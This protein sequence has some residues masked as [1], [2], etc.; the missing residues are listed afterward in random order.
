M[1]YIDQTQA[2]S[3]RTKAL[4]GVAAI[5]ALIGYGLIN[6]LTIDDF[7]P[8]AAPPPLTI[9]DY[10]DP[11]PPDPAPT[12]EPTTEPRPAADQ[13][14]VAPNPT[15]DFTRPQLPRIAEFDPTAE[16]GPLIEIPAPRPDPGRATPTPQPSFA[17]KGPAPSNSTLNWVRT[18][19][20]PG[21]ALR[22]EQEGTVSYRL[23]IGTDGKVDACEITASSGHEALDRAACNVISRR[24]R[25]DAAT[26]D[27]GAKTVGTYSGSVTWQIPNQ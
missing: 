9:R 26:N 21:T 5:H 23:L 8:L 24:A 2:S 25:F 18:E 11:P 4:I 7:V 19:D 13:T 6:G 12:P 1:A 27:K 3:R 14:V 16:L 10:K 20:Y 22:R 17:P 15:L